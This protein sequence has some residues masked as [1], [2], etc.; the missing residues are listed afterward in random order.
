MVK[1]EEILVS[2]TSLNS[3]VEDKTEKYKKDLIKTLAWVAS[4]FGFAVGLGYFQGFD[5]TVEFCAGYLLEQCLSIDNLFVFLL[6]FD[7]FNVK[8][9]KK[10]EKVL[11]YGIW[12][13]VILRGIF[14]AAGSVALGQAK[15]VSCVFIVPR[16]I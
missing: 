11:G 5:S 3:I 9:E 10:R 14:I 12:G 13:A 1:K 2:P 4:A 7:Y 16:G 6:L 15:Q 8:D